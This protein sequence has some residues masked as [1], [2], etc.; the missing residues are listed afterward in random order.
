M[1]AMNTMHILLDMQ[2]SYKYTITMLELYLKL[3][4]SNEDDDNGDN[5]DDEHNNDIKYLW[6]TIMIFA[7]AFNRNTGIRRACCLESYQPQ[8]Q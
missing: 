2:T 8:Q 4:T 6:I 3:T 1:P 7:R 5:D